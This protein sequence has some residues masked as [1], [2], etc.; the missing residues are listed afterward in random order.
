MSHLA[1]VKH[2]G[3]GLPAHVGRHDHVVLLARLARGHGL[4]GGD[5]DG[6]RGAHQV[7]GPGLAA[8]R[9]G[10]VKPAYLLGD[11]LDGGLEGAGAAGVLVLHRLDG[12]EE[13]GD[14]G[15]HDLNTD[16]ISNTVTRT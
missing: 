11:G 4:G 7:L 5:G 13:A 14:I 3:D 15:D 2:V 12:L 6:P 1:R 9:L 10:P 8:R 16:G